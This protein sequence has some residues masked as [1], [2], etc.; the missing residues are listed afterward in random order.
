MSDPIRS[1]YRTMR[2]N[3]IHVMVHRY[4]MEQTLGRPLQKGE[5][6]HHINGDRYDNRPEN[7]MLVTAK[8][9]ASFHDYSHRHTP[10]SRAKIGAASRGN[11]YRRGKTMSPET[12]A[13]IAESVRQARKKKFWSTRKK[14]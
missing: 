1:R 14:E 3:G 11:H 12:R 10:E 6:V 5:Q 2:A 9:H 8:N 13:Q 4:V 7:L